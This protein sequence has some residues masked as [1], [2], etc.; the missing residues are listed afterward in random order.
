MANKFVVVQ[1]FT[2]KPNTPDYSG[3]PTQINVGVISEEVR[4]NFIEYIRNCKPI[5]GNKFHC[6]FDV[7]CDDKTGFEVR[8]NRKQPAVDWNVSDCLN[9]AGKNEMVIEMRP[10]K[11]KETDCPV[12]RSHD[13]P[14]CIASGK[15]P[16]PFIQKYIGKVFFP[17]QYG[18]QR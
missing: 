13:C 4:K 17:N 12:S 8:P 5:D 9:R 14:L 16:S 7:Y 3:R 1:N 15:C 10:G 11:L 18:K 2:Y 6:G